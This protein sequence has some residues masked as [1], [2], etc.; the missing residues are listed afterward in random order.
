MA[1]SKSR[2]TIEVKVDKSS[3]EKA[4]QDIQKVVGKGGDSGLTKAGLKVQREIEK[5]TKGIQRQLGVAM[6]LHDPTKLAQRLQGIARGYM[7]TSKALVVEAPRKFAKELNKVKKAMEQFAAAKNLPK[8]VME[9]NVQPALDKIKKLTEESIAKQEFA[10]KKRIESEKRAA[11]ATITS[12]RQTSKEK[13]DLSSKQTKVAE[14]VAD[15]EIAEAKRAHVA[16]VKFVKLFSKIEDG[17]RVSMYQGTMGGKPLDVGMMGAGGHYDLV[18]GKQSQ[19]EKGAFSKQLAGFGEMH[20]SKAAKKARELTA[21]LVKQGRVAVDSSSVVKRVIIESEEVKSGAVKKTSGVVVDA[22]RKAVVEERKKANE[23]GRIHR[24]AQEARR[25]TTKKVAE[26]E[27]AQWRSVIL[28]AKTAMSGVLQ[29]LG[30]GTLKAPEAVRRMKNEIAKAKGQLNILVETGKKF[31]FHDVTRDVRVLQKHFNDLSVKAKDQFGIDKLSQLMYRVSTQAD[32]AARSTGRISLKH[33]EKEIKV[34]NRDLAITLQALARIGTQSGWSRDK[35]VS[36]QVESLDKHA[37]RFRDV[38]DR[39]D[40]TP[41]GTRAWTAG[42]QEKLTQAYR[43]TLAV[44]ERIADQSLIDEEVAKQLLGQLVR[45]R[46][47]YQAQLNSIQQRRVAERLVADEVKKLQ[48]SAGAAHKVRIDGLVSEGRRLGA[49]LETMNKITGEYAKMRTITPFGALQEP[50]SQ[51]ELVAL[52]EKEQEIHKDNNTLISKRALMEGLTKRQVTELREEEVKRYAQVLKALES[53][54]KRLGVNLKTRRKITAEWAKV[55]GVR[56]M[57]DKSADKITKRKSKDEAVLK[58]RIHNEQLYENQVK[59]TQRALDLAHNKR[60]AMALKEA[61]AFGATAEQLVRLQALFTTRPKQDAL[62]FIAKSAYR[63]KLALNSVQQAYEMQMG[64]MREQRFTGALDDRGFKAGAADAEIAK[65]VALKG[66]LD[67]LRKAGLITASDM[68]KLQRSLRKVGQA[69]DVAKKE[70]GL[71]AIATQ[72]LRSRFAFMFA[73][74]FGIYRITMLFRSLTEEMESLETQMAQVHTLVPLTRQEINNLEAAVLSLSLRMAKKPSDIAQGLYYVISAGIRDA[75]QATYV[76]EAATKFAASGLASTEETVDALTS[77]LNAYNMQARE[78]GLVT[79]FFFKTVEQGK[80]RP[81]D[82]ARDIGVM[83]ATAAA[84][85]VKLEEVLAMYSAL[86]AQG[87]RSAEAAISL[88]RF[89]TATIAP[90]PAQEKLF[91]KLGISYGAAAVEAKGLLGIV[92]QVRDVAG[93]SADTL[94]KI[95]DAARVRRAGFPA[96][97]RFEEFIRIYEEFANAQGKVDAELYKVN[98][99]AKAQWDVIKNK[100]TVS[101][102]DFGGW[103]LKARNA[104]GEFITSGGRLDFV[105]ADIMRMDRASK[106]IMHLADTMNRINRMSI[107]TDLTSQIKGFEVDDRGLL[108]SLTFGNELDR[109]YQTNQKS[110]ESYAEKLQGLMHMSAYLPLMEDSDASRIKFESYLTELVESKIP[111]MQSLLDMYAQNLK[112]AMQEHDV[113][114]G[115]LSTVVPMPVAEAQ[116][117]FQAAV[118]QMERFL[119]ARALLEDTRWEVWPRETPD[120]GMGEGGDLGMGLEGEDVAGPPDWSREAE[121]AELTYKGVTITLEELNGL[122]QESVSAYRDARLEA[123]K[124]QTTEN[125]LERKRTL[126]ELLDM[127]R[128]GRSVLLEQGVSGVADEALS[129]RHSQLLE[130]RVRLQ[131]RLKTLRDV[132]P[133]D[134]HMAT[135]VAR[136]ISVAQEALAETNTFI[137]QVDDIK[138]SLPGIIE[139]FRE[140]HDVLSQGGMAVIPGYGKLTKELDELSGTLDTVMAQIMMG[141]GLDQATVPSVQA[142]ELGFQAIDPA[143]LE[144]QKQMLEEEKELVKELQELRDKAAKEAATARGKEIQDWKKIT[145]AIHQAASGLLSMLEGMDAISGDTKKILTGVLK[146]SDAFLD[147]LA[148]QA[149]AAAAGVVVNIASMAGPIA[150]AVTGALALAGGLFGNP[151]EER[152]EAAEHLAE[153]KR[154]SKHLED[155]Q[156]ELARTTTPQESESLRDEADKQRYLDYDERARDPVTGKPAEK[157]YQKDVDKLSPEMYEFISKTFPQFLE[158]GIIDGK[159]WKQIWDAILAIDFDV[160]GKGF[161][162]NMARVGYA[163]QLAGEAALSAAQKIEIWLDQLAKTNPALSEELRELYKKDPAAFKKLMKEWG[164]AVVEGGPALDA[165]M[166]KYGLTAEEV[167][168]IVDMGLSYVDGTRT[169]RSTQ[170]ARSITEIQAVEVIAWLEDIAMNVRELVALVSGREAMAGTAASGNDKA[171]ESMPDTPPPANNIT[172]LCEK[173]YNL[174]IGDVNLEI[175]AGEETFYYIWHRMGEELLRTGRWPGEVGAPLS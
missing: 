20:F 118:T 153:L 82:L 173:N 161:K 91:D 157:F 37:K 3:L 46:E 108:M 137:E 150:A 38:S 152:T 60:V 130:E 155:I 57:V 54:A 29:E 23:G 113:V 124:D 63:T 16:K 119:E 110:L 151:D 95:Y 116:A 55:S 156:K 22:A 111:E 86:T 138:E 27:K 30:E 102:K 25:A 8:T 15:K 56:T 10:E 67:R 41:S 7:L 158:D 73:G 59:R 94:N 122:L 109:A 64:L 141:A 171:S 40:V 132:E 142:G 126:Q 170:I 11:N 53:E 87:I 117:N 143:E 14:K 99:T 172:I 149:E 89:I 72:F 140:L 66:S 70:V 43:A 17:L 120:E 145:T 159:E 47:E 61:R 163:I 39:G 51:R 92:E 65:M 98:L 146:I 1:E 131:E 135:Q 90:D 13:V 121:K 167:K 144:K 18:Q 106:S 123:A 36:S 4:S 9:H 42:E 104:M 78:A 69:A 105:I 112:T 48:S 83:V 164:Q 125:L 6:S 12:A 49:N 33:V 80:L 166:E 24:E 168:T 175:E 96:V 160:F 31:S 44:R 162:G 75:T 169:S 115:D 84:A 21:E 97:T 103:L 128:S 50:S 81:S 34:M 2:H 68:G 148:V 76:L 129:N 5:T 134:S 88:E 127:Y 35:I 154:I 114:P 62:S 139:R 101:W 100:L 85:G 133:E 107:I 174:T 165:I 28:S 52:L 136:D 147:V 71:L 79:D 77:V 45:Y 93:G 74:G 26:S 19:L 32:K 58:E